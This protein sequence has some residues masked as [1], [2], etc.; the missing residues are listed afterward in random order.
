[1]SAISDAS[2]LDGMAEIP[3]H[4]LSRSAGSSWTA[5]SEGTEP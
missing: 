5:R 3:W 1:M 2:V 4:G